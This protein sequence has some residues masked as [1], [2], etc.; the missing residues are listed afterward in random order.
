MRRR[1]AAR[2]QSAVRPGPGVS[3]R[4]LARIRR[5]GVAAVEGT[6]IPGLNA[7]AV[8]VFDRRGKVALVIGVVGRRETLAA[9]TRGRV[10]AALMDA[11]AALSRRLGHVAAAR[12]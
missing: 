2:P 3:A 12:G 10:A 1:A 9:R 7:L 5:E 8:P 6:L 11:S 4:V